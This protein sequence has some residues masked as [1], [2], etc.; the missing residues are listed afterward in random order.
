MI[1]NYLFFW[2][3]IIIPAFYKLIFCFQSIVAKVKTYQTLNL[4]NILKFQITL[5]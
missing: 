5:T 1:P 2:V 4:I 3:K